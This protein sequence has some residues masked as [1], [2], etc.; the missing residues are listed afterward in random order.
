VRY[1]SLGVNAST[2]LFGIVQPHMLGINAIRHQMIPSLSYS[3]SPD[4]AAARF[5][6]YGEYVDSLGV[7]RRYDRFQKSA[8]HRRGNGRRSTSRWETCSRRRWRRRTPRGR[9]RRCSS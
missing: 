3:L 9:S 5:G 6:Y 2:R 4:F 7:T 8:G 1:F